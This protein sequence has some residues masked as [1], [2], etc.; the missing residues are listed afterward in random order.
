MEP[1]IA[2]GRRNVSGH[3]FSRAAR[4]N[5]TA[6]FSRCLRRSQG[7]GEAQRLKPPFIRNRLRHD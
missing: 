3:D 4:R 7:N 2:C 6:G 1:L 5:K